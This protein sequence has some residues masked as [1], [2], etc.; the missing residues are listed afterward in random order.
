VMKAYK[1]MK[2]GPHI[3]PQAGIYV[4]FHAVAALPLEPAHARN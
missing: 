4:Q 3:W 1:S 2:K